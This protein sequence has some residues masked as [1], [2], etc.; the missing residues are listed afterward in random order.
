MS[1]ATMPAACWARPSPVLLL[2]RGR[3]RGQFSSSPCRALPPRAARRGDAALPQPRLLAA[4]GEGVLARMGEGLQAVRPAARHAGG[5]HPVQHLR[6]ALHQ[7]GVGGGRRNAMPREAGGQRDRRTRTASGPGLAGALL[8]GPPRQA[9]LGSARLYLGGLALYLLTRSTGS[10]WRRTRRWRV[11]RCCWSASASPASASCRRRWSTCWRRPRCGCAC[12]PAV[13]LHR[14]RADR[15]P[16]AGP[17]R[18][19]AG[20]DHG[21]RA[22]RRAGAAGPGAV[23]AALGAIPPKGE[24]TS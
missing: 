9:G 11:L 19:C 7:P 2:C 21:L 24:G 22:E 17:R 1:A 23:L 20:R 18:R 15:L 5:D 4:T 14:A 10:P 16:G 6:L 3:V 13:G 12:R 8:M